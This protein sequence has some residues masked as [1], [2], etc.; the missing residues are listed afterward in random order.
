MIVII[1]CVSYEL[2]G[3]G[4]V[5]GGSAGWKEPVGILGQATCSS[6]S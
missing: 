4:L 2:V 6:S 5:V 3:L 1:D